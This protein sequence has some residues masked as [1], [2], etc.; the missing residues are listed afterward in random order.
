[1]S[2]FA[3]SHESGAVLRLFILLGVMLAIALAASATVVLP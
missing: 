2:G 3:N 1:M